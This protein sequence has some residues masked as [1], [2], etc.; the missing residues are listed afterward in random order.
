MREHQEAPMVPTCLGKTPARSTTHSFTAS[1]TRGAPAQSTSTSITK[2]VNG[3]SFKP[4]SRNTHGAAKRLTPRD[5]KVFSKSGSS[6]E[7]DRGVLRDA[8]ERQRWHR[9]EKKRRDD[10]RKYPLRPLQQTKQKHLD[11]HR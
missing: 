5:D 10:V 7:S 9:D 6:L 3:P 11:T 2:L 1:S 8:K 4:C